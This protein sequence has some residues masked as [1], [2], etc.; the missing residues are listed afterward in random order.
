MVQ[1]HHCPSGRLQRLR[2]VTRESADHPIPSHYYYLQMHN[3]YQL[4]LVITSYHNLHHQLVE[5]ARL[6]ASVSTAVWMVT[7]HRQL[8]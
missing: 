8:D 5:T 1:I 2:S 3:C 4:K 6:L 7:R